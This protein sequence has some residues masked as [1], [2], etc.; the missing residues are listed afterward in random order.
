M[1]DRKLEALAKQVRENTTGKSLPVDLA[2]VAEYDGIILQPVQEHA[3]FNGKIEFL[4][5]ENVFVVYHPDPATYRYPLRLRFSIAHELAHYH[6]DEHREALVR[7]ET[8]SSESGFRS[9][10]PKEIQADEFAAALLIPAEK[11]EPTINKRGFLTLQ[12][13]R[14]V[15][16]VCQTSPYAT[17]IRYVR[18][19]SEACF[20]ALARDGA[21]KSSF[22]SD[23]AWI[24]RLAKLSATTLPVTSPGYHLAAGGRPDEV[25]E[26]RHSATA[27]LASGVDANLWESCVHIG[28][29]YTLSLVSVDDEGGEDDE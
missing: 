20:V 16:E 2:V 13:I 3:R 15:A 28:D 5:D 10:N 19:A 7:G 29:G 23:E 14:G 11:I 12:E 21:I 22:A 9:K 6:I 24:R 25:V 27:W 18:M 26:Q 1:F 17:A 8:H 4:P